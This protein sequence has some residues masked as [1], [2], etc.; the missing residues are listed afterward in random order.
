MCAFL[1]NFLPGLV[2]LPLTCTEDI[3][4][5]F[6]YLTDSSTDS[7]TDSLN[8]ILDCESSYSYGA[9]LVSKFNSI[10]IIILSTSKV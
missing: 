5:Y 9:P 6:S 3:D 7:D 8:E 4:D 2:P 1:T 10:I